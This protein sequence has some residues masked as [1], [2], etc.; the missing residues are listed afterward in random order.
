[1]T[2][3]GCSDRPVSARALATR[4]SRAV[5]ACGLASAVALGVASSGAARPAAQQRV[6]RQLT[7]VPRLVSAHGTATAGDRSAYLMVYFKDDTHSIYFATSRDGFAF[8]DVNGGRPILAGRAIADQKGVRDPHIMRGPDGAFY[9]AM[10]DLHIFGQREGLRTT[11]WERPEKEYG[12]GN[13]RNLLLMKS[14]DLL[15][16]TLAKVDVSRLFP[17]YKDAGNAWAPETIYDPTTR[18]MMVYFTTRIGNGPNVM[19]A[20][21]ANDAFTTLTTVPRKILDYPRS[22]VNTIDADI[23]LVG[24]KYRMFYVAHEKPGSIR[25]AVSTRVDR[26]YVY[27]ARKIDPETVAAEAPNLWRR[28]GT[29]T[30]VLMYDVF[31]VTPNNMG[32]A[33]TKDFV[34][35]RNIGRFNDS[36]SPMKA[37][38][39]V[40]P[41]HGAVMAVTPKEVE[42][43]ERYFGGRR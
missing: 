3:R 17:A 37:T 34:T 31:G 30:W 35:F 11:E 20:S 1:M 42:R 21:Q 16:W 26:G 27:D 29:H 19:V 5:V 43:L 2:H 12:W 38:N 39:F 32:F 14:V 6:D 28:H 10:T 9:M 33:E 13:N 18:R 23:T 24:G 41:K 4:L 15:H 8:T 7:I 22:A 40:Q 25:Q 36:G